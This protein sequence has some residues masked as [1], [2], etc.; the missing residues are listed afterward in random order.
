MDGSTRTG[1]ESRRLFR[2]IVGKETDVGGFSTALREKGSVF[3]VCCIVH[4]T[5]RIVLFNGKANPPECPKCRTSRRILRH[6]ISKSITPHNII[7]FP[8]LCFNPLQFLFSYI[9]AV[10]VSGKSSMAAAP[11]LT[12]ANAAKS[13][14]VDTSDKRFRPISTA[15]KTVV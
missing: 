5:W 11:T 4:S 6:R 10:M 1:W 13:W 14:L 12:P 15:G 2:Q 3:R 7:S 8:A 9:L